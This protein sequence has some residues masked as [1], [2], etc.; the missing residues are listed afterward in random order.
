MPLSHAFVDV[1]A[2]VIAWREYDSK[3]RRDGGARQIVITTPHQQ[4]SLICCNVG[5]ASTS[6]YALLFAC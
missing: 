3:E 6:L 2:R 5:K 4:L 1:N